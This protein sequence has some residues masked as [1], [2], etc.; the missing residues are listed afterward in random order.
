MCWIR[1]LDE[2]NGKLAIIYEGKYAIIM[3]RLTEKK[4]KLLKKLV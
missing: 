1:S 3:A 4:E 2:K